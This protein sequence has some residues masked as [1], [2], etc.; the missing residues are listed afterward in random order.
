VTFERRLS[1]L[2]DQHLAGEVH[3][4]LGQLLARLDAD[5]GDV[6]P[7]SIAELPRTRAALLQA[8]QDDLCHLL[9]E[10]A[11]LSLKRAL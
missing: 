3:H 6:D 5:S 1:A 2:A 7:A 8:G 4:T 11:E 10:L 9:G